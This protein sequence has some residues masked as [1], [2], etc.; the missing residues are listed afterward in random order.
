MCWDA[1]P[2]ASPG[3]VAVGKCRKAT[4]VWFKSG[5]HVTA[6]SSCRCL[7]PLRSLTSISLSRQRHIKTNRHIHRRGTEYQNPSA[8]SNCETV[9]LTKTH[10]TASASLPSPRSGRVGDHVGLRCRGP[11]GGHS[12][13]LSSTKLQ[14]AK[15]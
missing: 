13:K 1:L 6:F 11:L 2:T 12:P 10:L 8:F 14:C 4:K 15:R 5:A 7:P 9:L 3:I